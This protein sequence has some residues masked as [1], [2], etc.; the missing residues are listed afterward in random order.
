MPFV[1]TSGVSS[2]QCTPSQLAA[3]AM[4][5]LPCCLPL[6]VSPRL[7]GKRPTSVSGCEASLAGFESM[8]AK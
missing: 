6:D 1:Q 4:N 5:E 7:T 2:D 3:I 8:A